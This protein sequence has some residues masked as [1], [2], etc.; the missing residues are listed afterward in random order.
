MPLICAEEVTYIDSHTQPG[1]AE[2]PGVTLTHYIR[3]GGYF[4]PKSEWR[5]TRSLNAQSQ[6]DSPVQ[7]KYS[8]LEK[9]AF[10]WIPGVLN[11]YRLKLLWE[12][13]DLCHGI[14][15]PQSVRLWGL[16][17]FLAD[18]RREA[19]EKQLLEYLNKKAPAEYLEALTPNY[20]KYILQGGL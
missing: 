19:F 18:P 10:R 1:V 3:S 16:R 12:V 9:F 2:L 20:R 13:S 17:T 15:I 4:V 6:T 5:P 11:A 14:P 7:R 8:A